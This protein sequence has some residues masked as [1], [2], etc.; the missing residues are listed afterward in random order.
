MRAFNY[1]WLTI[2]G[3]GIIILTPSFFLS[4]SNYRVSA[5]AANSCLMVNTAGRV[6]SVDCAE[7][8]KAVC[9]GK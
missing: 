2:L 9:M 8:K 3:M 6:E 1:F 7:S 5:D 4:H